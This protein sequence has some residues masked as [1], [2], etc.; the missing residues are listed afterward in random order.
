MR[1]SGKGTLRVL[2][3]P[4]MS[5]TMG[6]KIRNMEGVKR[7]VLD[8]GVYSMWKYIRSKTRKDV[9]VLGSQG[10][11]INKRNGGVINFK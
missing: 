1:L 2:S 3:P 9:F 10:T 6:M 5:H 8:R 7:I 11:V 4:P